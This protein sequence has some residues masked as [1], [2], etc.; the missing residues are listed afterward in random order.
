M[1]PPAKAAVA[2]L[3]E[4]GE[5]VVDASR[6]ADEHDG[7]LPKAAPRRHVDVPQDEPMDIEDL[8][9]TNRAMSA[10][11]TTGCQSGVVST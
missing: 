6:R 11:I 4:P 1:T 8:H 7:E 3:R 2:A 5:S 9:P 10:T